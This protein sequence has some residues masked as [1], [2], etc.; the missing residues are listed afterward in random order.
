MYPPTM[1]ASMKMMSEDQ[2]PSF[3]QEVADTGCDI[4]AV[5]GV[6]FLIGDADLPREAYEIAAPRLKEICERYGRRDHLVSEIVD[7]LVSIGRHFPKEE[8]RAS[9]GVH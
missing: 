6:G 2:I 1:E 4:T 5:M 8:E 7:Y 3:V 9:A